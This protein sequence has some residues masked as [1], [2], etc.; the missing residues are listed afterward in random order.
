MPVAKSTAEDEPEVDA[1]EAQERPR[2]TRRQRGKGGGPKADP[3][4]VTP[5]L[6][7]DEALARGGKALSPK[8]LLG[9][10]A[11]VCVGLAMVGT[12]PSVVGPWVC[13]GALL[14]LIYGVHSQGRLGPG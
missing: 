10:A 1:A 2:R 3:P 5:R 6:A 4:G 7:Q 13:L 9:G 12:G 14:V 11:G 8:L